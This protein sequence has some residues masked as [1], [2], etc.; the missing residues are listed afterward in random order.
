MD[1]RNKRLPIKD[2]LGLG[3]GICAASLFSA[4]LSMFQI[5]LPL[6]SMQIFDRVLPSDSIPTLVTLSIFMAGLTLCAIIID[7][8]RAMIL[9]R[10]AIRLD[11]KLRR[12]A[13]ESALNGINDA[14]LKDVESLRNFISGPLAPALLDAPWSLAFLAAI[15]ALHPLLGWFTVAAMGL[16]ICCGIVS[17]FTTHPLRLMTAAENSEISTTIY[18]ASLAADAMAT[19]GMRQSLLERLSYRQQCARTGSLIMGERQAWIDSVSRGLRNLVQVGV[20]A[21]AAWLVL[22]DGL[23]TGVIV[24]TSMLFARAL[25]PA[26]RLG[27]S[28]YTLIS[29]L[30]AFERTRIIG[31]ESSGSLFEL[32]PIKG[33][34]AVENVSLIVPG[35]EGPILNRVSLNVA[36]GEVVVVVGREGAGKSSLAKVLAGVQKPSS[37]VVRIDG[38]SVSDFDQSALGRQVSFVSHAPHY[39]QGTIADIIAR[40]ESVEPE[41]VHRAALTAGIHDVIQRLP[42][43]YQ[44]ELVEPKSLMSAGQLQRLALARAFYG[45]PKIL[46]F[47]E[48]T[49]SLDDSGEAAF[50]NA[51]REL[52]AVGSTIII[53]SRF[54]ALI[55][56]ADRLIMLDDG[57]V[58]LVAGSL[59]MQQFL[60]PKLAT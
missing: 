1:I 40:G 24:A 26:E 49:M 45:N 25:A 2:G 34:I 31:S 19:M 60:G 44:T 11:G 20:M 35:R 4:I 59:D 38:S 51:L 54:P 23:Q 57:C 36:P 41:L 6:Y 58:R 5:A 22:S 29:L 10:I 55:H 32:P 15:F 39:L 21:F 53:I 47:D 17:H 18:K 50:L 48:P 37:G 7:A 52:K 14:Q 8:S 43:G 30:G 16:M 3:R 42:L 12:R 33:S 28:V 27:G 46:V 9:N 56:L 13:T